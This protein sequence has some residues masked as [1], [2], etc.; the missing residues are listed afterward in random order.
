ML[1]CHF[2][3]Q[4]NAEEIKS[5]IGKQVERQAAVVVDGNEITV[6][7]AIIDGTSYAPVR[8]VAEAVGKKVDW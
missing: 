2:L 3:F 6:A 7:A 4:P 8:A 1:F 5:L